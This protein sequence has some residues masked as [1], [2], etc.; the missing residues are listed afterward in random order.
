MWEDVSFL[1]ASSYRKKIASCLLDGPK[2]PSA[3]A[4]QTNIRIEHVTRAIRELEE[5]KLVKCLTPGS[6]RGRLYEITR[7]GKETLSKMPKSLT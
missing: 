5:R 7:L 6:R 3:I 1:I 4:K 2:T